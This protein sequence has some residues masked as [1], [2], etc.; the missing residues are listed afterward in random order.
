MKN[1]LQYIGLPCRTGLLTTVVSGMQCD[2]ILR[3]SFY[4]RHLNS[5]T[6]PRYYDIISNLP[7]EVMLHD[8]SWRGS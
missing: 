7:E 6:P 1:G 5:R 2:V 4:K 3:V 8:G